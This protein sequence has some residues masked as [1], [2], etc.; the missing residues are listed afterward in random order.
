MAQPNVRFSCTTL[1]GTNKQGKLPKD[2]F[3]YYVMPIG[4]LNCFNSMGE[5]YTYEGAKQLFET[6]SAFMRRVQTGCLKSEEGHPK[7]LPGM[8][9]DQFAQRVMS[10]DEKN[11]CAHIAEIY[12]DFNNVRDKSGKPIIAIMGKIKPAG[13]HG[14]ALE[15]S[16]NNPKEEVCFSIRAFTDDQMVRGVT[17]RSLVEVVT[18][19]HVGEPGIHTS[20][21]FFSPAL[22]EMSSTRFE[23]EDIVKATTPISGFALESSLMVPQ[24]LFKSMGWDTSHMQEPNYLKW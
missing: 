8:S 4:G 7:P 12:L 18:F 23:K 3:G 1:A 5:Y 14:P 21:K 10:I 15:E 20:K 13:P 6:S 9:R 19:D 16:F 11:V 24:Q 17:H 22:E 2:E